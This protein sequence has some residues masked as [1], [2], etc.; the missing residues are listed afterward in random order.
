MKGWGILKFA[1]DDLHAINACVQNSMRDTSYKVEELSTIMYYSRTFV[2]EMKINRRAH[3]VCLNFCFDF[4][5]L[6]GYL[7]TKK[8]C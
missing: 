8:I 1:A 5:L 2:I 6:L 4:F 3:T 7:K